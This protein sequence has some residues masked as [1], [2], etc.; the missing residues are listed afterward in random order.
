MIRFLKRLD[1]SNANILMMSSG[2]FSG[3]DMQKLANLFLK[4]K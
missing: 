2:N 4:E 1:K 3:I